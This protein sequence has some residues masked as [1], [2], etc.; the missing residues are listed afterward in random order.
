M[1][2]VNFHEFNP[3]DARALDNS[4]GWDEMGGIGEVASSETP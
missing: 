2:L 1:F 4:D 3:V